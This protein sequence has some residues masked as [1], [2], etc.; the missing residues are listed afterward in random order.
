MTS[1]EAAMGEATASARWMMADQLRT[2]QGV[3]LNRQFEIADEEG[4]ILGIIR[5]PD[6]LGP[7][8]LATY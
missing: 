5:F 3:T 6:A 8:P 2:N 7:R 1:L 4:Q